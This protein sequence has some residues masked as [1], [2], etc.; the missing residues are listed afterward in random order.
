MNNKKYLFQ[1]IL[2]TMNKKYATKNEKGTVRNGHGNVQERSG[3]L[4]D[5]NVHINGLKRLQKRKKHCNLW[6]LLL[7]DSK[8]KNLFGEKSIYRI[9][10]NRYNRLSINHLPIKC[11][12]LKSNDF[13]LCHCSF[14]L[15]L[16]L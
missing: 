12:T 15:T 3:T 9:G 2:K 14:A 8:I 1:I 13:V 7:D 6:R 10:L 5:H 11:L 16:I 4:N